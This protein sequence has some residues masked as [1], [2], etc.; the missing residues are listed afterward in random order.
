MP[1]VKEELE[2][3]RRQSLT[4]A[5]A[6]KLQDANG[7]ST[8]EQEA[9]A[10]KDTKTKTHLKTYK[11]EAEEKIKAGSKAVDKD[12]DFK[13]QQGAKKKEDLEKKREAAQNLQNFKQTFDGA[14]KAVVPPP[15]ATT[16]AGKASE[17]S[18]TS[19]TVPH[20]EEIPDDIDDVPNLETV[21]ESEA[22]TTMPTGTTPDFSAM[23]QPA[24]MAKRVPNRN[25]KKAR[26]VMERLG[27]KPVSGIARVTLK[28]GG[29][30]GYFTI[31]QPDVFEK[32]GA[33][34]VFGEAK[35]GSG[36]PGTHQQQVEAAQQLPTPIM[37]EK[38]VDSSSG[39]EETE[40]EEVDE[41][42]LDA[43]DIELVVSQAGCSR[44]RAVAA[45]KSNDGD[46]VNAIMSLT[47]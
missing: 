36:M 28:M 19:S 40:E 43:K 11:K 7:L 5:H 22:V 29:N 10:L 24:A 45:L 2:A 12:L 35:Q 37:E 21:E 38:K 23:S 25:E 14:G 30:Q 33:Y 42:G 6:S 17:P 13:F 26:K 15:A 34:V 8:P 27:M 47:N 46:L 41:T 4:K 20:I 32:S 9:S 16:A 31:Y 3:L 39:A 44:A 18:K 1:S